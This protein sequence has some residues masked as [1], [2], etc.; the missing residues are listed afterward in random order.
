[1]IG[2]KHAACFVEFPSSQDWYCYN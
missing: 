1:M 2:T